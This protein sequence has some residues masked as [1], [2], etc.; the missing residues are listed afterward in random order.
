M[1]GSFTNYTILRPKRRKSVNHVLTSFISIFSLN[2]YIL[3]Y[4]SFFTYQY[5]YVLL[6]VNLELTKGTWKIIE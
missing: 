4:H 5:S 3:K 6:N 2:N 1:S